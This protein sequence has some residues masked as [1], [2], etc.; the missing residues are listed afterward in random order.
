MYFVINIYIRIFFQS[1]VCIYGNETVDS[2][3]LLPDTHMGS[4]SLV[5]ITGLEQKIIIIRSYFLW[6]RGVPLLL[7]S[8]PCPLSVLLELYRTS[9]SFIT[10]IKKIRYYSVPNPTHPLP[11]VS[12]C[13]HLIFSRVTGFEIKLV[14]SFHHTLYLISYFIYNYSR[15]IIFI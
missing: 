9:R 13:P 3:D 6:S 1:H 15:M 5:W 11:T 14:V 2:P 10:F 8:W 12:L 4:S 7:R